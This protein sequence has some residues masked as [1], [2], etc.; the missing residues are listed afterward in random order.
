MLAI[1]IAV[2]A[3]SNLTVQQAVAVGEDSW[4][5][6]PADNIY[7]FTVPNSAVQAATGTSA[8]MVAVEGNF[9]PG[10]TWSQLNMS[11]SGGNWVGTIGPLEPGLYYYH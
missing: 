7:R 11:L 4:V 5:P 8:A 9:G 3:G 6:S 2:A 1:A 10:N